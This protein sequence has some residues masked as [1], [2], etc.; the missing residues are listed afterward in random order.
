M[1]RRKNHPGHI[2]K[3]AGSYRVHLCV[4]GERH[5]YTLA[6][7]RRD[8]ERFA[9]E[10]YAELEREESR[11]RAGLPTG[12]RMSELLSE[13]EQHHLPLLAP[14][15]QACYRDALK[16][17]RVYFVEMRRD[18]PIEQIH[19]AHIR[20][21]L[22]WRRTHGP[23]G[24]AL[25]RPLH[26]RT[27]ERD[28]AVL[29]KMFHMADALEYRE[30]NPVSRVEAPKYDSRDPVILSDEQFERLLTECEPKPML[31]LWVLLLGETGMR[32]HSEALW[33]KWEDVDTQAGFLWVDSGSNGHR[34]KSGKGR[35]V[36]LTPR[37]GEALSD[38]AARYR[39]ATY[40]GQRSPW[41]LH[42]ERTRGT[43]VAGQRIRTIRDSLKKAR[44]AAELPEGFRAHD[45]RHRRVT[46]WLAEGKPVTM[47]KEAV[48]HSQLATTM[49]YQHLAREHL[50]ALVD[51]PAEAARA[52]R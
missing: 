36:P 20:Q 27:L 17:I 32:C 30:G 28:R 38:H 44:A 6:C 24:D 41:L 18:P 46:S 5:K 45:L 23:H 37:L 1:S 2:E 43:Y 22:T 49:L 4:A 9:R 21:Y 3:R 35:W 12:V 19:A 10:K 52:A 14:R 47:V 8:A 13:F 26:G 34:T 51:S 16:P 7:S 31:W 39:L 50:K 40:N 11:Y 29:H 25:E 33:L 48:G 42:H 15:S